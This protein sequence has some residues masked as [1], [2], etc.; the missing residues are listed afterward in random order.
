MGRPKKTEEQLQAEQRERKRKIGWRAFDY[1]CR[2]CMEHVVLS[3]YLVG[4]LPLSMHWGISFLGP[5]D[6]RRWVLAEAWIFVMI[7]CAATFGDAWQQRRKSDGTITL[8]FAIYSGFGTVF[9]ALAYGILMIEPQPLGFL[10]P[11]L[12]GSAWVWVAIVGILYLAIR[13]P[14]LRDAAKSEAVRKIDQE[15]KSKPGPG[16]K[17]I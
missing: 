4:F 7:T 6:D 1:T 10:I 9:G 16:E 11:Y 5:A 12:K 14:G 15:S 8:A 2:N 13:F 3:V 17:S